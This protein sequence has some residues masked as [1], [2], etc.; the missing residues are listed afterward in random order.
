MELEWSEFLAWV[1]ENFISEPPRPL[2]E[3]IELVRGSVLA[4]NIVT[5]KLE[6]NLA[7]LTDQQFYAI[8][9]RSSWPD[10]MVVHFIFNEGHAAI[11]ST[12]SDTLQY[13]VTHLQKTN[14]VEIK[15]EAIRRGMSIMDDFRNIQL[16]PRMVLRH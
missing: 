12:K 4:V 10:G 7:P 11:L 2:K 3:N 15:E 13:R 1:A 8:Q 16:N 5:R 9:F 6:L 14:H